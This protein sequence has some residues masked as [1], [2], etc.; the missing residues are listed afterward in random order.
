ME[1]LL[2]TSAISGGLKLPHGHIHPQKTNP[3]YFQA[4][5]RLEGK[6]QIEPVEQLSTQENLTVEVITAT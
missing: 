3:A 6:L 5:V 2:N 1:P 4:F